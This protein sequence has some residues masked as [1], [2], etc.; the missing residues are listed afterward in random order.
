MSVLDFTNSNAN[1]YT[2]IQ[3]LACNMIRYGCTTR[4][5][6][7]AIVMD[8]NRR[9][10]REHNFDRARGHALGADKLFDVCQWCY[11]LGI[12][13]LSV[14]AFSLENLKRSKEEVDT[15]MDIARGKL[16]NIENS[17]DKIH[18]QKIGIRIIGNLDI[19]SDDIRESSYHLINETKQYKN[20]ILNVCLYYTSRNEM[21]NVIKDI[22]KA[23][24][25]NL[26]EISDIDDDLIFQTLLLSSSQTGRMPDIFLRTSGELRLSD[27]MLYQCRFSL[28]IFTDVYWPAF[29][30]WHLYW[31]VLHY[32]MKSKQ[33]IQS[34][35]Q[36]QT[37]VKSEN[38]F[39]EDKTQR[40]RN[41]F[42]WLDQ[43]QNVER[44]KM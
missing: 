30:V 6:H 35:D 36:C 18:Q 11:D 17:L 21:T 44:L 1:Q 38:Q 32:E 42:E 37:I 14:Y 16:K 10:A 24:E 9:F 41:Y 25:K 19:L 4:P 12:N 27:F 7:L 23:C 26:L 8:G 43:Q 5:R 31:I 40:I 2:W 20:F 13:E 29:S 15:L 28:W 3:R 22:A 33:L 34:R 39:N